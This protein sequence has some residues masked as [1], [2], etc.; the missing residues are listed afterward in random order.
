[1][2][3]LGERVCLAVQA[4]SVANP[5]VTLSDHAEMLELASSFHQLMRA[6]LDPFSLIENANATDPILFLVIC[7]KAELGREGKEIFH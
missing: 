5:N 6:L 4:H 1:M 3:P 7:A 2:T